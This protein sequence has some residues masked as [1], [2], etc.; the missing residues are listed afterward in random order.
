VLVAPRRLLDD[1]AEAIFEHFEAEGL[2]DG[3]PIIPPTEERVSRML[4]ATKRASSAVLGQMPPAMS[5]VTLEKVAI[6][7]VMA[8]CRPDYLPVLLTAV[9]VVLE[10]NWVLKSVQTTTNPMTPM[11]VVNGPVRSKI[12]L[13]SGTGV[14]GP[15]WRANATIGRALRLLLLDVGGARPGDV[16]KCTQGFSGKYTLC[17][18]ENEEESPWAPYHVTRGFDPEISAV[19]VVGVNSS[20]NIHDS[21]HDWRDLVH[22]LTGGLISPA[23]ANVAD[24]RSTPV[25]ALNPLHAQI[26]N[27]AGWSRESLQEHIFKNCRLPADGLSKR[28]AQLRR[29]ED[30]E[31]F[32]VDGQIPFT[33]D[34]GQIVVVVTGGIG[35]GHS[36]YLPNGH[37]GYVA[38]KAIAD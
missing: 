5:D 3:L 37:F 11:V 9:E 31:V 2:G 1:D 36:C 29:E 16:D 17:V 24:P 6:C 8:G 34:P 21:S 13:N 19:T 38:T 4:T 10:P 33:N 28:R 12:G 15:G 23:T 35:G 18:G 26:L 30:P 20:T 25:I 22:S 14:M 7:A 27:N 32:L